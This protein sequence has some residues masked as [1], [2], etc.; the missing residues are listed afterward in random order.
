MKYL[1]SLI[2]ASICT[3][4]SEGFAANPPAVASRPNILFIMTDQQSAGMMSCAGNKYLKTPALDALAAS[5]MRF[6]KAYSP[7]PVCIPARTAIVTGRF[8]S[9]FGFSSNEDAKKA[10]VPPQVLDN[11]MGKVLQRAGYRT[12]YGG[13]THWAGGLNPKNTGFEFLTSDPRDTLAEKCADFL[14]GKQE[15]PFFL[16]A[17]FM[18]PHDICYVGLDAT[19]KHYGLPLL[20]EKE[21][22][23]DR[24]NIAAAIRLADKAKQEGVYDALCPP[25][26]KNFGPTRN[27]AE[28][29][30]LV[31]A[32]PLP[33]GEKQAADV[34]KYLN[35]FIQ[36]QW[37]EADWR[38]QSWIYHRLT[39]DADRQIGIVLN[40][41]HESGLD[42]NTIVIFTSDHGEMDGAHGLMHKSHFYDESA[43]VPFLV[44]GPGVA[45]GVNRE[46]LISTVDLLPTF[47]DF[48]GVAAPEGLPGR[49]LKPLA[50]GTPARDAQ[51]FVVS[52]N[53]RGRMV[54]TARYKYCLYKSGDSREML[55][56]MEA[57][58]GEMNNLAGASGSER[59]LQEH[60][61]LLQ[62]WVK[63]TG[64][65]VALDYVSKFIAKQK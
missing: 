27:Q 42:Q 2:L 20:S 49:S 65:P 8:P 56:D 55:F 18:N 30:R 13:K 5:G 60:R 22:T 51:N 37:Q 45:R 52:E 58:P 26:K 54:R 17:S 59:V 29:R 50:L 32:P 25:L 64:D 23:E 16:V 33:V 44:S 1:A 61:A 63:K 15:K 7:N 48:A 3:L 6:E 10:V 39:E 36:N 11:T 28:F 35:Y 4:C 38:L 19:S 40:A 31:V 21:A 12:V 24:A 14:R 34:Y 46:H 43:R 47:C 41:L 57:D 9:A 53:S 62:D